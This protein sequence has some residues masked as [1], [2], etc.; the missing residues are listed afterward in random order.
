MLPMFV[1][2]SADAVRIIF[3]TQDSLND[4]KKTLSESSSRWLDSLSFEAKPETLALLPDEEGNI[5]VVLWGIGDS[6]WQMAALA[7]KLPAGA[8]YIDDWSGVNPE[9]GCLTWALS[10]YRFDR[11]KMTPTQPCPKL[12][13]PEDVNLGWVD[14]AYD[15]IKTIRDLI[16]T[17]AEDLGPAEL[18][19]FSRGLTEKHQANFNIISG[20]ELQREYPAIH[21]V[22]RAAAAGPLLI[23]F[24]WSHPQ[25][26]KKLVLVGK[27]VCFDSGGLDI[28]PSSGMLTM[29]KD[30]G[31]AAHVLGL[32]SMI[33]SMNLP[34]D[35]RVL[36][37]AVE[38]A[39]SGN[40]MRPMDVIKTRK[41]TTVE[42]G[43]TDAEGRL[44]LSDA[45]FEASQASPDLIIDFATL[46]GA[47]RIAMGTELPAMF[48]NN[49]DVADKIL[50]SG[51]DYE[52][53]L[54]RMPLYK[55]YLKYLKSQIADLNNIGKSPYGGAITAA[56]F[57]EHFIGE[58]CPWVHIDLMAWNLAGM[59]GRPEG[60]EAMGILA[61]YNY[62]REWLN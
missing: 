41:G 19:E 9:L 2:K 11:Y 62:L 3:C 16:N 61:I 17:P 37:P 58:D 45:L 15:A 42:I 30:M 50:R 51:Q 38:N 22:G 59:P 40:A 18:A 47:A 14:A 1:N 60:G 31:G 29:K 23:D 36:I 4:L 35:L 28:K 20:D 21:R 49:D 34:V 54:W 55:P 57:L 5:G 43:N 12:V 48:S 24:K 26:R 10:Q 46:T 32:A 52:D 27:G 25:P 39:I 33:M 44:I 13:V 8:Y 53:E 56:L 6:K 7:S